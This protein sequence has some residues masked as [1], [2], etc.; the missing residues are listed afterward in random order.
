MNRNS[1]LFVLSRHVFD[2]G[3]DEYK[4]IMLNKRYLSFRVIKVSTEII[5]VLNMS[6][7]IEAFDRRCRERIKYINFSFIIFFIQNKLQCRTVPSN[8]AEIILTSRYLEPRPVAVRASQ[9]P[10]P[11][12][13]PCLTPFLLVPRGFE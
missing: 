9:S 8:P 6:A 13:P 11:P 10:P 2:D 4:I 5:L 12:T 7:E 1:V 3:T